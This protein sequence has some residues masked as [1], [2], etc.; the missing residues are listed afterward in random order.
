MDCCGKIEDFS[1]G[2]IITIGGLIPNITESVLDEINRSPALGTIYV[3]LKK[4]MA[5]I[6]LNRFWFPLPP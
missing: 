4:Q 6:K 3:A 5:G 2:K 1:K